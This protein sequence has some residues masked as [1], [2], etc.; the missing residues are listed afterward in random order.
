M[1]N[2]V[3]NLVPVNLTDKN[4]Q[5]VP[6][7][8]GIFTVNLPANED[9]VTGDTPADNLAT[10]AYTVKSSLVAYDNIGNAVTLD[11]Y[12]T[13]TATGPD[14]WEATVFDQAD[15][16]SGGGFPYSSGSLLATQTLDFDG[17]GQLTSTPTLSFPVPNGGT[18]DLDLSGTTQLATSFTPMN[19]H[20]QRQRAEQ[21]FRRRHRHRR[22]GL[23]G[24]RQRV[25]RGGLSHSAGDRREPR[26]SASGSRRRLRHHHDIGRHADRLPDRR[27]PRQPWSPA[28]WSSRT[29]TW[30]RS[31][32]T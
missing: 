22:H 25:A 15:A 10:S 16:A 23:R 4:L 11:V 14:Q 6:T 31:S 7:T 8:A 29:S 30:P 26:Q 17:N 13:K 32:P 12:M 24:L 5:A 27:R 28:R 1:L 21:H 3:G 20:R 2:G 18:L 19:V 9:V